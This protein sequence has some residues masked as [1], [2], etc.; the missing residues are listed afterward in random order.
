MTI[1]AFPAPGVLPSELMKKVRPILAEGRA[2]LA[3]GYRIDV[4]GAEE[5]TNA[6]LLDSAVVAITSVIAIYFMLLLQFRSAKKPF[7]VFAAIPFGVAAAI[8]SVVGMGAPFGFTAILDTISLIGVIVSHVIVL[9]DGIEHAEKEGPMLKVHPWGVCVLS[10][11][12]R[13]EHGYSMSPGISNTDP[14]SP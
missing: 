13:T 7:V 10:V 11:E 1:V 6:T 12:E 3:P 5:K 2:G 4:G 14:V 8:S 9:F